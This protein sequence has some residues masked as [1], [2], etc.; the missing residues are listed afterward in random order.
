MFNIIL[1]LFAFVIAQFAAEPG[2]R[3]L[4]WL[5][6]RDS[7]G[8]A[9]ISLACIGAIGGFVLIGFIFR[10]VTAARLRA[11]PGRKQEVYFLAHRFATAYK[12]LMLVFYFVILSQLNWYALAELIAPPGR[13]V[14]VHFLLKMLPFFVLLPASWLVYYRVEKMFSF[15]AWTL[16]QYLSFQVRQVLVII[17]PLL[18]LNFVIELLGTY[19]CIVEYLELYPELMIVGFIPMMAVVYTLIPMLARFLWTVETFPKGYLRNRMEYLCKKHGVKIRDI[20]LWHTGRASIINAAVLGLFGPLRYVIVTD[21]LLQRLSDRE[22]EAVFG[23]ELGH[24]KHHHIAI[25]AAFLIAISFATMIIMTPLSTGNGLIDGIMQIIITFG[26]FIGLVFGFI[27]RRFERQADLFGCRVVG[28]TMTFVNALEKV[29]LYSG[30]VRNLRSWMHSSIDKRVRFLVNAMHH[31]EVAADFQ[32]KAKGLALA[33]VGAFALCLVFVGARFFAKPKRVRLVEQA[34][35]Y[36]SFLP[37]VRDKREK[38]GLNLRL[39]GLYE[40]AGRYGKA[41]RYYDAFFSDE[42]QAFALLR[43]SDD[44]RNSQTAQDLR[45]T[46]RLFLREGY[47]DTAAPMIRTAVRFEPRNPRNVGLARDL[48]KAYFGKLEALLAQ[49]ARERSEVDV[50]NVGPSRLDRLLEREANRLLPTVRFAW[51][52]AHGDAELTEMLGRTYLMTGGYLD[53]AY[54]LKPL[55]ASKP[56]PETLVRYGVALGFAGYVQEAQDA[57]FDGFR[58]MPPDDEKREMVEEARRRVALHYSFT[59][60]P[61]DMLRRFETWGRLDANSGRFAHFATAGTLY[62]AGDVETAASFYRAAAG[63]FPENAYYH[64][65][66]GEIYLAE[67]RYAEACEQLERAALMRPARSDYLAGAARAFRIKGDARRAEILDNTA[68]VFMNNKDGIL[69]PFTR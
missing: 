41:A 55:A 18:G 68:R 9:W 12:S 65:R 3:R 57:L 47:T 51:S 49:G 27:S 38:L 10:A 44:E 26:V 14:F 33:V 48:A 63:A 36:E 43:S 8:A 16:G 39:A 6:P 50:S 30:N 52:L 24:A 34:R 53:A 22:V 20:L 67:G 66:L 69:F 64:Y 19:Q 46:G 21:G 15:R 11:R 54:I 61:A 32:R 45:D 37:R 62:A 2:V 31:P 28:D 56:S 1:I 13:I 5:H 59:A 60:R 4:A 7:G 42:E 23:H 17:V 35:Y 25:Y 40:R 58:G 29:A